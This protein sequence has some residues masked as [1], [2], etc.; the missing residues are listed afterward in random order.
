MGN[1]PKLR[2]AGF[3]GDLEERKLRELMTF[4]NGFNGSQDS[5]GDGI[6]LI[7]VMDVLATDFITYD[8]IRGCARL[9]PEEQ[10][11]FSVKFGDVLFQR[12]SENYEDAG[13]SNIYLDREKPASFGG[14]VIRGRKTVEYDPI[15]MRYL[16]SSALVRGQIM[17]KAQGA[18]HINV[19][20]DILSSLSIH[21][22]TMQEQAQIGKSIYNLD[23]LITLH[24]HKCKV[25]ETAKRFY[26]QNI[27][28]QK[29]ERTP[30]MRFD[31]FTGDWEQRKL[32][33]VIIS[34]E[35]GLN[36]AA[37]EFDG[38]NKYLRITDIDDDSRFF[39]TDD[40][41]SPDTDLSIADNYLLH[42]G[43]VLFARTGASVGK[44]FIYRESDGRV[45]FAGF[46]IM[47]RVKPG[48]CA[49]FIF[50]N[51]LTTQYKKFIQITSQRSGQPGVNAKEYG[52]YSF[53]M[54]NYTEQERIGN[55]LYRI[56]N[57]I[58]LHHR[59]VNTLQTMKQ[60]LLQNMFV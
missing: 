51:T 12:S 37:K 35:Y 29:D 10:E 2:F 26:L 23:Q 52:E 36:A 22:P 59:K 56:D 48:Y 42:E 6:P 55:F 60:F 43:D 58:T 13:S 41:T 19:S 14:F 24:Q 7:S 11:R 17:S 54:P 38:T 1:T 15:Y 47:A 53:L 20:Q 33:D 18:Q 39:R 31:G 50:Q 25:L 8:S 5:F 44:S 32:K 21:I 49:D 4:Q 40:L 28:P 3:E 34:F 30:K 9:S 57:L 46:L 45:Y 27:F 16:L